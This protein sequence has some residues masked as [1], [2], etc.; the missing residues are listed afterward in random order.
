MH[1][2]DYRGLQFLDPLLLMLQ[3]HKE[4]RRRVQVLIAA[5]SM[6]RKAV[7]FFAGLMGA[8][9]CTYFKQ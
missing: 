2:F 1:S 9:M 3:V 4:V 5:K 8:G 6:K 7:G